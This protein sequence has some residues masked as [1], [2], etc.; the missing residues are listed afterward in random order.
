MST[1]LTTASTSVAL[2]HSG[3]PVSR[4]M[5]SA[6]PSFWLRTALAKRRS[7][8]MRTA[9]GRAA[10]AAQAPRARATSASASPLSPVQRA[11]PVAGSWEV[12]VAIAA[13]HHHAAPARSSG[14]RERLAHAAD[15]RDL[16]VERPP[17]VRLVD[18]GPDRLD[19]L[20]MHRAGT[21]VGPVIV[22]ERAGDR[23]AIP[24]LP[25]Q[26]DEGFVRVC[27]VGGGGAAPSSAAPVEEEAVDLRRPGRERRLQRHQQSGAALL[28][29]G[30]D[31]EPGEDRVDQS[32][33]ETVGK[34]V[35]RRSQ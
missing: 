35:Q 24:E 28:S 20:D 3:L 9:S 27:R 8:S 31:P 13:Y 1:L 6:K 22:I 4:A 7:V 23:L 10:Q 18:A 14:R 12:I 19:L 5:R 15:R 26:R 2:S 11:A 30:P 21:R 33:L 34:G 16:R 25:F 17:V 29:L 32:G